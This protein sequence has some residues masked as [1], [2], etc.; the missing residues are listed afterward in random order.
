MYGV[1]SFF[2]GVSTG[3]ISTA[4]FGGIYRN[5]LRVKYKL[6]G[7]LF[8]DCLVHALCEPCA[9]C[10]EY[11]ELSRFGFE[12]PLGWKENMEMQRAATAVYQVAPIIEN[13]M[14]R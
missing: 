13:G 6:R 7:T 5:K 10:Q 12:V 1:M 9:L 8:N 14:M 11:R 3:G 4:I 2:F